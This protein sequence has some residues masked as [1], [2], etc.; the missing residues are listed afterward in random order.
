MKLSFGGSL[1]SICTF[2]ITL[3]ACGKKEGCTDPNALNY[4]PDAEADRGCEYIDTHPV[5]AHFHPYVGDQALFEGNS[6]SIEGVET[7][8][9]FTR[10]YISNFRL[11]DAAG[12]ET[13]A[14]VKYLL[15]LPDP[16]EYEVGD[17][18]DGDYTGIRFE[19]GVDS[20]TN[21]SDP[22]QYAV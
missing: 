6:Y 13:L 21:H 1:L 3:T 22:T 7:E 20:V 4:D 17:I 8:L 11:V 2:M 9:T 18:P 5:E 10:F 14:P 19:I 16:E 12:N 15:V